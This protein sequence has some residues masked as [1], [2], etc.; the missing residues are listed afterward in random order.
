MSISGKLTHKPLVYCLNP[1]T[2]TDYRKSFVDMNKTDPL[3]AYIIADFA[4]L[5]YITF[6]NP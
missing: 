3:D 1:K 4:L 6:L 2:V 5:F